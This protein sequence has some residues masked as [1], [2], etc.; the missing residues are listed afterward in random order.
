VTITVEA[1][2]RRLRKNSISSVLSLLAERITSQ[3]V[4][5]VCHCHTVTSRAVFQNKYTA[6]NK[7]YSVLG[8]GFRIRY[9]NMIRYSNS[10][11]QCLQFREKKPN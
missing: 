4:D 10:R 11:V 5:A 3:H 7:P 6:R 2:I 1:S 8:D 9:S